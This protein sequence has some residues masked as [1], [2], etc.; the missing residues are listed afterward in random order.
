[1]QKINTFHITRELF[2]I[3]LGVFCAGIG[4]KAF[5]LPNHFIDGGVMGISILTTFVV[6]GSSSS[7]HESS[8]LSLFVLIFNLPFLFLGYKQLGMRFT[9]KSI[10]AIVALSLVL[11]ILPTFEADTVTDN[12]LL[13]A[14]F[15][16]FFLGSGIGFSMRGEAVLDGTEVMAIYLN[17]KL[18]LSVGDW[19]LIFNI[20]IFSVAAVILDLQ[21]ALY[22]VVTYFAASKAIN[23]IVY[24]VEEY[25]G[26]N[27]VSSHSEAIKNAILND[28]RRGVTVLKGE[29]G[30]SGEEQDVLNCVFTRFEF[31]R[32]KSLIDDYDPNAFVI[33]YRVD[34]AIGG[35]IKRRPFQH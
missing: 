31:P 12:K 21:T 24:G 8:L 9:I 26:V 18:G 1:M 19:I 7:S 29:R 3:A 5:I 4:L 23:F 2:F 30:Y 16:G 6:E 20:I 14:V 25:I 15:G 33:T 17:K 34:S 27:I 13:V 11:F 35:V 32:L 10:F 22:S 28:M